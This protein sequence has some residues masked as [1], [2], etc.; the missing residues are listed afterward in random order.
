MM[1]A[2]LAGCASTGDNQEALAELN[3]QMT[4]LRQSVAE[5]NSRVE[6]LDNKFVL[7]HEK[8][9]ARRTGG[10]MGDGGWG[11]DSF[12]PPEGLKVVRLGEE[13]KKTGETGAPA[14]TK[15]PEDLY[16][17]GQD[18]FMAGRYTE[19]RAVFSDL[20]ASYPNHDLTDNALYWTG[21]SYYSEKDFSKALASF[22]EAAEKYPGGNKAPDALLKVAYSYMELDKTPDA[23][24]A[25]EALVE[26]YP[27][28]EAAIKAKKT[29]KRLYTGKK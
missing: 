13:E 20:V 17:R 2:L 29:L 3:R 23:Q 4:E 19:A 11:G 28:S 22:R 27:D 25:L 15:G 18:L 10:G 16:D 1:A 12:S 9:E 8:L 26:R 5:T 6:D 14:W 21:E 7:L 24:K